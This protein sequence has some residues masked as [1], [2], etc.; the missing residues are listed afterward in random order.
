[1]KT[2]DQEAIAPLGDAFRLTMQAAG[3]VI[4]HAFRAV[5]RGERLEDP[6]DWTRSDAL[7]QIAQTLM[8]AAK[9]VRAAEK[10]ATA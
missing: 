8:D 1:M 9:Q 6:D 4:D 7:A 3:I 2:A 5:K 10:E